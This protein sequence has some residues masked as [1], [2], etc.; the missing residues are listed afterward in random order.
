MTEETRDLIQRTA[1]SYLG[2]PWRHQGR[3]REFGVDCMGLPIAVARDIGLTV[4]DFASYG[5]RPD[6]PTLYR[7]LHPN[8]FR[9]VEGEAGPGDL[10][11]LDVEG[12]PHGA[13]L[14]DGGAPLSIV[15]AWQANGFVVETVFEASG[16]GRVRGYY[17][18]RGLEE[19]CPLSSG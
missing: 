17:R 6:W 12:L 1:R 10:V 4:A 18:Y 8:A 16:I 9:I 3:S 2:V 19:G 15:H 7:F 11:L 14:A 13:I 5:L